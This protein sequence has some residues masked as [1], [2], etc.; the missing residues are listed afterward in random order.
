MRFKV[1]HATKKCADTKCPTIYRDEQTGN[2]IVQGYILANTDKK[3]L[4]IP[5]GENVVMVPA[6]FLQEYVAKQKA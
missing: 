2:F 4:G 6:E 3:E 1:V 5:A